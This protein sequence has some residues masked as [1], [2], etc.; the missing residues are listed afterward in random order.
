[1]QDASGQKDDTVGEGSAPTSEDEM[2]SAQYPGP[3]TVA[4]LGVLASQV[5]HLY[6]KHKVAIPS[7]SDLSRILVSASE[8]TDL[9]YLGDFS[10]VTPPEVYGAHYAD[11]V[12]RSVLKLARLDDAR[13]RLRT[14]LNGSLDPDRRLVSQAKNL[15]WELELLSVLEHRGFECELEEPDLKVRSDGEDLAI[16]CKKVYSE[17]NFSKVMSQGVR[18]VERSGCPG[19]VAIQIDDLLHEE[20]VIVAPTHEN[21][22]SAV[23]NINIEFLSR[24]EEVLRKYLTADRVCAVLVACAVPG[25][26]Q[27]TDAPCV[28]T[29]QFTFWSLPT[30]NARLV[31]L[32]D[33]FRQSLFS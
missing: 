6:L 2:Y 4:E 8:M 23:T 16:A 14:L 20:A 12:L 29:R 25:F 7:T 26:I 9:W 17:K 3:G 1:M 13:H 5:R 18:Q 27:D 10:R 19:M 30:A 22:F 24:N 31:D 32:M 33:R 28:T 21:Y 15:L 11:R